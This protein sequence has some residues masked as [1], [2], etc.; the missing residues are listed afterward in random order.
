VVVLVLNR[1]PVGARRDLCPLFMSAI[2][3]TLTATLQAAPDSWQCR[4]ALIEALLAEGRE[5]KACSVLAQVTELP[6][7]VASQVMAGRAYGLLDASAGFEV[8]DSIL[9]HAPTCAAAHLE[10]ARLSRRL[11]DFEGGRRHYFAA[12]AFDPALDSDALREEFGEARLPGARQAEGSSEI[13][14][15]EVGEAEGMVFYPAPGELPVMTL[16][17]AL[18]LVNRIPLVD[19]DTIP[20]HPALAYEAAPVRRETIHTPEETYRENLHPLAL[21]PGNGDEVVVYDFRNPN[22]SVF[23][24]RLTEDEILVGRPVTETGERVAAL[25][26]IILHHREAGRKLLSE[27]ERREKLQS[28]AAG[29]ST[30]AVLCLL[31]LLVVTAAPRP[32]PPQILAS[33]PVVS[34]DSMEDERMQRPEKVPMPVPPAAGAMAMNVISTAVVSDLTMTSVDSA[35][36]GMGDATLGMSFGSSFDLGSA[37]GSSAM[38]FGSK[39]TGRRFLFVLD[40]SRSMKPNQVKLRN[41]ELNRTLKSLRGIDYQVILFAGGA[42]FADKGWG[43]APKASAAQF[44]PEKFTSPDGDYEFKSTSLFQFSLVG[45]EDDFPLPKWKSANSV[46]IARSIERVETSEL[47]SGTDWDNALRIAHLMKPPPDVI[48][49]MSDGLDR[50]LDASEIVRNSKKNGAPKINSVAMQTTDGAEGFSTIARRTGGS[51]T[52]VDKDGQPIDGFEFMKDPEKFAG[53]L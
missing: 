9:A 51:Y 26:E 18:G 21:R 11:E 38:F 36:F 22:N 52:I 35:G 47:F 28:V 44:G 53:R 32:S 3:D 43:I 12:L 2:I 23:E 24:R 8:L 29:V 34:Q 19:P 33:A 31:M 27:T 17:E 49:F 16:R 1:I 10:K 42:Y 7:D 14:G 5:A 39:A 13:P 41:E 4:L 48:F 20:Q 6:E 37:G 50:E 25:Q 45:D 46:N 40:A 30:T 15:P